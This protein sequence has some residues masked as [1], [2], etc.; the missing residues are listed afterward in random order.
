VA[1]VASVVSPESALEVQLGQEDFDD[2][3]RVHFY[4]WLEQVPRSQEWDY[5]RAAYRKMSERLGETADIDFER[6]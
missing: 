3:R 4:D 6:V 5:R 1:A 2:L